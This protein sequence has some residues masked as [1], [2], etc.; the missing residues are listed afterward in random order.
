MALKILLKIL[1]RAGVFACASDP[2]KEEAWEQGFGELSSKGITQ[3]FELGQRIRRRYVDELGLVSPDFQ[4]K[5][6]CGWNKNLK[7]EKFIIIRTII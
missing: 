4:A 6:V 7:M 2:N 3:A 1:D 5:E